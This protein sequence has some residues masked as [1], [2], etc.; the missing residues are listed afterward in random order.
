MRYLFCTLFIFL[1]S[2]TSLL[3]QEITPAAAGVEYGAGVRKKNGLSIPDMQV[4]VK[5]KGHYK[6]RIKGEVVEV[7]QVKG[8]WMRMK[9][10]NGESMMVRFRDYGFFMPSNIIG[11]VV[12][13]EGEA[14][15]KEVTVKQQQHYAED[16]G[17]TQDEIQKITTPKKEIQFIAKGV[18]VLQ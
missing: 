1:F 7:C 3:A 12:I 5:E 6:G 2:F 18:R 8:C 13:L 4:R 16:G 15:E 17:K 11:H 14:K 10:E 9:L